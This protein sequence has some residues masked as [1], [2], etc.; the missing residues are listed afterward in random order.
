M[1]NSQP[2]IIKRVERYTTGHRDGLW[3]IAF[4]GFVMAMMTF[5]L[6]L[7]L[8]SSATSEWKKATSGYF[9]DPIGLDESISPYVIDLGGTLTLAPSKT[10]SS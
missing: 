6:V 9:Q 7:W 1:D 5:F 10:L 4:A 2:I 8:P 3:K